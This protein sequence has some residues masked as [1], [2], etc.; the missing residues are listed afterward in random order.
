MAFLGNSDA[1]GGGTPGT[2][3][4]AAKA[5]RSFAAQVARDDTMAESIQHALQQHPGY[6]VLH[7]TGS[8]H[9]EAFLAPSNACKCSIRTQ[10]GRH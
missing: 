5:Q 7:L 1:H 3:E 4:S 10:S 2:A 6:K 9:S 8:F